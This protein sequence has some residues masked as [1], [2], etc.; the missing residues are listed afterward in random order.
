MT[1]VPIPCALLVET[2]PNDRLS[3]GSLKRAT[4]V[5]ARGP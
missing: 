5:G 4:P 2:F 1:A 3:R